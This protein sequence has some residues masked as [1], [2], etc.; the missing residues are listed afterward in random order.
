M[1]LVKGIT[2][3]AVVGGVATGAAFLIAGPDRVFALAGQAR[4]AILSR[5]DH[6]IQ[7]PVALRSQLRSL[8]SE[9]PKR[10]GAVRSD[11]A[12]L[13]AHKAELQRE[14]EVSQKVVEMAAA[15]LTQLKD[16]LA[17]AESA[18][19]ESPYTT[20]S[21]RFEG[22]GY[23]L[24]QAYT[25]ATQVSNTLGV[26]QTRATEAERDIGFLEQQEARLS[27]VLNQLE[28]ERAQFQ[29]Q[30][31]QLDGQIEM[32]ARNDKL[33][34]LV[35]RRQESIDEHSRFEAV[36][37]S[38]ITQRMEKIRAEQEARLQSLAN[39]TK[40]TDYEKKAKVMLDNENAAKTLF[41]QTQKLGSSP[42]LL[43]DQPETEHIEIGPDGAS[44]RQSERGPVA[45]SSRITI[46]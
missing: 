17:R 7:D 6:N 16:I 2:R 18:R 38:Q 27:E 15:D 20:I 14:R 21:V 44:E 39:Q 32:I 35:E 9:Y 40:V 46:D 26:Y 1:C 10:I 22:N 28:T 25:R 33:I 4:Q 31:F 29:A 36:S 8:E 37:L 11:L 5:I 45:S 19:Q 12:E 41:E 34:D 24:D 13:Q 30:I 23:S 3:L 42:A 43:L